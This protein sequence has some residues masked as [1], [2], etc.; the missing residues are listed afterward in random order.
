MDNLTSVSQTSPTV[1]SRRDSNMELFR[2]VA[3]LLVM[4]VHADFRALQ[5]PTASD[6]YDDTYRTVMRLLVESLSI[7]CVNT[8][9]LLSG[10]FGIRCRINRILEFIFQVCFFSLLGIGVALFMVPEE[11]SP[12]RGVASFFLIGD[13]DYWFV[14]C[15][16]LM[17]IFVPVMNSFVEHCTERQ[18]RTFL[19]VFY[20]FQSLYGFIGGADWFKFGYSGLSF[21]GLYLL[22]RYIRL[23][24]NRLTSFNKRWDMIVYFMFVVVMTLL[25][26]AVLATGQNPKIIGRIYAYTSPLVIIP[27]IYFLLFFTKIKLSYN[28]VI[29]WVAASCFAIYLVHSNCW[30]ARYYNQ[31]ISYFFTTFKGVAFIIRAM[32]FI[33]LVFVGSILID[34]LR[35]LFWKWWC[36]LLNNICGLKVWRKFTHKR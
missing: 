9:V 29:N 13:G 5:V 21:M 34:K 8:F 15:Y 27:S 4:V 2:I 30:L 10:W 26:I 1:W 25:G 22:A 32:L 3:M 7:I 33:S 6:F 18:F 20:A 24:P 16:L 23:Y 17:Y 14:K 31:A 35:I 28:K 11:V 12:L 36:S 19:I